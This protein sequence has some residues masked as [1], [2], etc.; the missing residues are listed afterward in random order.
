MFGSCFYN[1]VSHRAVF[2]SHIS[3]R[4]RL[5][6]FVFQIFIY[7]ENKLYIFSQ[8]HSVVATLGTLLWIPTSPNLFSDWMYKAICVVS[9]LQQQSYNIHLPIT[10]LWWVHF[11]KFL[12]LNS[13]TLQFS[14]IFWHFRLCNCV[15]VLT[16]FL[17]TFINN[18]I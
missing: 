13:S 4:F 6:S 14:R 8:F 12:I 10:K 11:Y 2:G 9:I 5:H 17:E 18:L 15:W 3:C 1:I 7:C 16:Y